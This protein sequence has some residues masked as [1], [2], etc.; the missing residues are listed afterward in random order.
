MQYL[1]DADAHDW[2]PKKDL[3]DNWLGARHPLCYDLPP[4]RFLKTG[5]VYK[6][7]GRSSK[8]RYIYDNVWTK[9]M[10]LRS[11][12][13]LKAA[14]GQVGGEWP[15]VV[16]LSS[17]LSPVGVEAQVDTLRVV[18]V[19]PEVFYEY[20]PE[21]CV[22]LAFLDADQSVK[23][24]AGSAPGKSMCAHKKSAVATTSCCSSGKS[25]MKIFCKYS[26][27][28]VTYATNEDRC[29]D[30]GMETCG[31]SVAFVDDSD[32]EGQIKYDQGS[33]KNNHHQVGADRSLIQCIINGTFPT[34]LF[35]V[36][37]R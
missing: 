34:V 13:Q 10:T 32:C 11:D 36:D 7:L 26:G 24:F 25:E 33:P 16:T 14:L 30:L 15:M 3:L 17:D 27:E 35:E 19:A 1:D 18:Q 29:S 23:V 22:N 28:R 12:S 37:E 20:I 2:F 21:T 9:E 5:A 6:L 4:K 8:P 31:A